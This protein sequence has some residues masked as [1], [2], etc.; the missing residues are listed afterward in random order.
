MG[1][2]ISPDL[3]DIE[4]PPATCLFLYLVTFSVRP[5]FKKVSLIMAALK[6]GAYVPLVSMEHK[7]MLELKHML[8]CCHESEP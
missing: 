2:D 1:R 8:L 6:V 7:H 4:V 5:P 3:M